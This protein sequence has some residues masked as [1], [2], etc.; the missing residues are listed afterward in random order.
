MAGQKRGDLRAGGNAET[1]AFP[2]AA[3]RAHR[4]SET[5]QFFPPHAARKAGGERAVEGVAGAGCVLCFDGEGRV[6]A[7]AGPEAAVGPVV[8]AQPPV[9]EGDNG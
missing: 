2:G 3:K 8:S 5:K 6:A 9:A 1:G 7:R 4:R